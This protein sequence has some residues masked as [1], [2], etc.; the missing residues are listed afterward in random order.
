MARLPRLEVAGWPHVVVQRC[1][2]GVA[3]V[4]DDEDRRNCVQA[5]R[6][7]AERAGVQVHA[8]ALDDHGL[9]AVVTP[10]RAGALGVWM[11]GLGRQY[12]AAHNRRHGRQGGLWAA[13]FRATVVDPARNL[14]PAMVYVET[15]GRVWDAS[16]AGWS[17]AAHHL[18]V[19]TQTWLVDPPAF[20]GLGN[21]PFERQAIWRQRLEE[22]LASAILA[23]IAQAVHK[24]WAWVSPEQAAELER[25]AGRP[26]APRKRG[27]PVGSRGTTTQ[28]ALATAEP[29]QRA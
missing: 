23:Q 7:S 19:A 21:T 8:Y 4:R 6:E 11:Q 10:L 24:A 9:W 5:L 13:R 14:L 17:S 29:G 25:L 18:G 28:P 1:H 16:A 20:W 27:R 22:G 2:E 12:V 3:L 15:R 26:M